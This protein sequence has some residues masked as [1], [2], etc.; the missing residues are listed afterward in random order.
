MGACD[1][2]TTK[3]RL[4]CVN[5]GTTLARSPADITL[6]DIFSAVE[7]KEADDIFKFHQNPSDTC[8]VGSNIYGLLKTHLDDAVHALKT[9]LSKVTLVMLLEELFAQ[10]P[11]LPHDNKAST[12]E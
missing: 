7:S 6:W 9:E 10:V 3:A 1:V 12:I 8:S 5:L 4:I 2:V 11:D